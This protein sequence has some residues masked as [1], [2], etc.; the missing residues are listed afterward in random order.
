M[1]RKTQRNAFFGDKFDTRKGHG[2]N[3]TI[4]NECHHRA[5]VRDI[6]KCSLCSALEKFAVCAEIAQ[7]G[8]R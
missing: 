1:E 7:L 6:H 5:N 3:Q 2:S 8:E 4:M